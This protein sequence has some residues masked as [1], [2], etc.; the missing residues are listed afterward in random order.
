VRRLQN[1]AE[2]HSFSEQKV[3]FLSRVRVYVPSK[4]QGT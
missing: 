2:E 3:T 4:K 1:K